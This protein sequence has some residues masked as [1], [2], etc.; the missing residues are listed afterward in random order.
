MCFSSQDTKIFH[1][2]L[3]SPDT[4][5]KFNLINQ[6]I[7]WSF[8][9]ITTKVFMIK[10]SFYLGVFI[11]HIYSFLFYFLSEYISYILFSKMTQEFDKVFVSRF[12]ESFYFIPNDIQLF[13][14]CEPIQDLSETI[15]S[16]LYQMPSY[17]LQISS[18]ALCCNG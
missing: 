4:R 18:K 11:H 14:H 12:Y 1:T 3:W 17:G 7:L 2:N 15:P 5:K 9:L 13:L 6:I 8:L 16:T 10:L